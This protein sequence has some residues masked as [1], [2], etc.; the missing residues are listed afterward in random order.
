MLQFLTNPPSLDSLFDPV[1]LGLAGSRLQLVSVQF[2]LL[3]WFYACLMW[4][5]LRI[6]ARSLRLAAAFWVFSL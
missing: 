6:G 3:G 2:Y 4:L 5:R 1:R